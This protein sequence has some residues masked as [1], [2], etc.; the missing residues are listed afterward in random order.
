MDE[1]TKELV[2]VAANCHSYFGYHLA[3]C[4]E[5]DVDRAK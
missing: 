5:L 1:S 2:T 3:R 4:D